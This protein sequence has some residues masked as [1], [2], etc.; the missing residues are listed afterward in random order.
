MISYSPL[1][2]TIKKRNYNSLNDFVT[3]NGLSPNYVGRITKNEPMSTNTLNTLCSILNCSISEVIEFKTDN[4]KTLIDKELSFLF[5]F[6][7]NTDFSISVKT[8]K[9]MFN[10][11]FYILRNLF[12]VY[13][14]HNGFYKNPVY[15]NQKALLLLKNIHNVMIQN[16]T[17]PFS[18]HNWTYFK[19]FMF[20]K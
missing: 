12:V 18:Y 10:E 4:D 11:N 15:E 14:V 8:E 20:S 1:Y 7:K 13:C 5:S 17:V 2:E 3:T 9:G 6:A 19:N 16:K